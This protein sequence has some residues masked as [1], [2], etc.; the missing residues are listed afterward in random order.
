MFINTAHQD[1]ESLLMR[2]RF[3]SN[4][5][6]E[7]KT[8][9]GGMLNTFSLLEASTLSQE[10][11]NYLDM[12]RQSLDAITKFVEELLELSQLEAGIMKI[13]VEPFDLE[14]EVIRS[15]KKIKNL[16][17][18]KALT[19]NLVMDYHIPI[20]VM[21]DQKKIRHII[22]SLLLNSLKQTQKGHIECEVRVATQHPL[23]IEFTIHDTS[24]AISHHEIDYLFDLFQQARKHPSEQHLMQSLSLPITKKL[25]EHMG[26]SLTTKQHKDSGIIYQVILPMEIS[27]TDDYKPLKQTLLVALEHKQHSKVAPM[28]KSLGLKIYDLTTIGQQKVDYILCETPLHIED[29][30]SIKK[31]Y[32]HYE[33]Q[34]IS[35]HKIKQSKAI[36]FDYYMELPI[37]RSTLYHY[38]TRKNVSQ[39]QAVQN[40][41]HTVLSG[42]VLIVDD[43]RLN[44]IALENILGKFGMKSTSVESGQKAIEYVKKMAFDMIL[45]DIQMPGMDGVE[46]TRRIRALGKIYEKIPIVAVTANA[47]FKDYDL[48]KH[49]QINDV[50][51]KPIKV[52]NLNLMLRKYIETGAQIQVPNDLFSFDEKD[53]KQ[54]FEGSDDIASEV[55]SYF[56]ETYQNDLDHIKD[57]V[58]NKQT[59]QIIETT[60]YFKGSCGYLSAIRS[61]WVLNQMMDLA[62]QNT[63][64]HIDIYFEMLE[65]EI[66]DLVKH[67]KEYSK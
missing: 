31:I 8:P 42:H 65:H 17:M 46:A 22:Q 26:G 66:K 28:F 6:H 15:F 45:M 38:L 11:K 5:S 63:L 59:K 14:E 41:Y 20:I 9:L 47:F 54:R 44:R 27:D 21:G 23:N 34:L 67:L 19:F 25:I 57:A 3:L 18:T 32:A 4:L 24:E 49:A 30:T 58:K 52:D 16:G 43:N 48:M 55:L 40:I 37:S 7:L 51:F 29:I 39:K 36:T 56:L 2:Q 60:H 64:D 53:F 61:V 35:C 62:K 50:I 13:N 10:Q 33:T 12:G 1:H